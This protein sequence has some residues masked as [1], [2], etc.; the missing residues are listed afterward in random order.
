METATHGVVN[1]REAFALL[2]VIRPHIPRRDVGRLSKWVALQKRMADWIARGDFDHTDIA[3][4]GISAILPELRSEFPELAEL[5]IY[6][7]EDKPHIKL[8]KYIESQGGRLVTTYR[9]STDNGRVIEQY[10]IRGYTFMVLYYSRDHEYD[11][12]IYGASPFEGFED[13][14]DWLDRNMS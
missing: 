9:H 5:E 8:R 2:D 14:L 1:T 12:M 3:V 4:H 7:F 10:E 13:T 6:Q 11:F